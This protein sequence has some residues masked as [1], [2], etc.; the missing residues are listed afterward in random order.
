MNDIWA[1]SA[2]FAVAVIGS[3]NLLVSYLW[4]IDTK[5]VDLDAV[6]LGVEEEEKDEAMLE[7]NGK[8]LEQ[9]LPLPPKDG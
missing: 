3:I 4:L 8:E 1:A 6:K 7:K 9:F 5:G 2:Y